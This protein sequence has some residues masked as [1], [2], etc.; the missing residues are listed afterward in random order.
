[1]SE[2]QNQKSE[3]VN[4]LNQIFDQTWNA[5][6]ESFGQHFPIEV[7]NAYR[8]NQSQHRAWFFQGAKALIESGLVSVNDPK[9][10]P[11]K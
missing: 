2:N 4:T 3:R 7:V 9:K 10:D 6:V 1:M 8:Q 11:L 5:T